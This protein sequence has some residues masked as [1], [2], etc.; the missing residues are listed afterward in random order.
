MCVC[1]CMC[2]SFCQRRSSTYLR[3][4]VCYDS[5]LISG[6]LCL[7]VKCS[8]VFDLIWPRHNT[9]IPSY[10]RPPTVHTHGPPEVR[11]DETHSCQ[12]QQGWWSWVVC[13]SWSLR[14]VSHRLLSVCVLLWFVLR[15][16]TLST[17]FLSCFPLFC[18]SF[19]VLISSPSSSSSSSFYSSSSSS[20][21]G[22]NVGVI[23]E[24]CMSRLTELISGP[25][26]M[27]SLG[28]PAAPLH[29]D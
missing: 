13:E 9:T 3:L 23:E 18:F 16:R 6:M 1:V 8:Q 20:L 27:A 28:L 26:C 5:G 2:V 14:V 22:V 15:M 29:P 25:W 10:P 19:P 7:G 24:G 12:S 4:F 17:P 11:S 21:P